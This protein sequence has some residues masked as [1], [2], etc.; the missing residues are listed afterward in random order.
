LSFDGLKAPTDD[1]DWLAHPDPSNWRT[2][3]R[4]NVENF[5]SSEAHIAGR[6]WSEWRAIV[7]SETES[8][9]GESLDASDAP[10]IVTG[11]Q[12]EL[13]HPGVWIKNFAASGFANSVDGCSLHVVTDNDLLKRSTVAVPAGTLEAPLVAHLPFDAWTGEAPFEDRRVEDE[14]LFASFA[15]RAA[16][17]L[18]AMPFDTLLP[19]FWK[20]ALETDSPLLSRRFSDPRRRIEREW[21]STSGETKLSL[22][23]RPP[24]RGFLL[25]A[26]DVMSRAEEYR[27]VYNDEL[28]A[29][30]RSEKIRS[31]H[32]PAPDLEANDSGVEV[33]FWATQPNGRR[34][35]PFVL[36]NGDQFRLSAGGETILDV[37]LGASGRIDSLGDA[38]LN[39]GDQWRI[40]PRALMTTAFLRLGLADFFIH[41]LG[42]AKYDVW[43]DAVIRRFWNIEPP[44]YGM[45]T[46]TLRL[47]IGDW[48]VDRN[49]VVRELELRR[50]EMHWNPD[51]HIDDALLERE[52]I[53]NWVAE[54][55]EL[56]E[57]EPETSK[58]RKARARRFRELNERLREFTAAKIR[59]VDEQLETARKAVDA[60]ELMG[61]REFFFGFHSVQSLKSMLVPWLDWSQPKLPRRTEESASI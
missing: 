22:F 28:A 37:S 31:T 50:R 61:S 3:L 27:T 58:E 2:L 40:R 47:P 45:I 44:H 23:C 8:T 19:E 30:R 56:Q 15:E 13:F 59:T 7:R 18:A 4:R 41:G 33:P 1:G 36:W 6:R 10:L 54:K 60:A 43:N 16:P 12:P 17:Y 35:R 42:G 24:K 11:H 49:Q 26:A 51:R 57:S 52:P 25:L 46:A 48:T 29:Y 38:L 21:G 39:V 20:H 53:C 14:A 5:N 34:H 32:H 9:C 55:A